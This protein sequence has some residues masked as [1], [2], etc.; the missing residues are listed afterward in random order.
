MGQKAEARQNW[1]RVLK[2]GNPVE[3]QKA[4]GLLQRYP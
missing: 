1:L 4:A 2:M 3:A